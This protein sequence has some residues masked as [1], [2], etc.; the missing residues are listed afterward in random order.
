MT[1]QYGFSTDIIVEA[2][3]RTI[4]SVA[5]PSFKYADSVLQK[6]K[7]KG[8]RTVADLK[9][10]DDEY[11]RSRETKAANASKKAAVSKTSSFSNFSQRTYDNDDMEK[12]E[13]LLLQRR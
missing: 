10:I 6:W 11:E 1:D 4:M 9:A 7:K 3:N 13:R 12:L 2:C 5:N 8:V